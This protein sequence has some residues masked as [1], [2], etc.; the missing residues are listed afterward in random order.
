MLDKMKDRFTERIATCDRV[1]LEQALIRLGMGLVILVYLLYRY[2]TRT[3]LNHNDT[4]SFR[5]LGVFLLLALILIGSILYSRKPSVIRR[6]AGAWVDQG[7]TTLFMALTGEVGVVLVGVYLWVIFGNGFRFGNKYLFHAQLLS[8]AGFIVTTQVSPYWKNHSPIIYGVLVMLFTL[9]IY[10]SALI[11]RMNEARQKAEEA[12]AAKTRFVANMSHEIRTPLNGIIGISTLLKTTPLNNEQQ[13]LLGM[14]DSSSR[15]LLS[16]LNN[17]LD[18]AKIEDGKMT[19]ENTDFSV[20]SILEETANIFSSQAEVKGVRLDTCI[21]AEVGRLH[22]DS[23]RL[24]QVLAN[25]VGNAVKFTERGSVTLSFSVLGEDEHSSNVRFEVAD[26]GVGIPASAQGKIF[27]S[28]TQ[29]DLSTSRRFG[30]SGLGLTLTKHLVEAMGGRLSFESTEGLGSRFWFDLTLERVTQ[31]QP[32]GA[33]VVLLPYTLDASLQDTLH[34][35]VCENDSTNQKIL[36]RL[37]ELAGHHVSMTSNGEELLDQLEQ[38]AFDLVI[39]DLNM[40]GMSGTE[41]L[42]LYRFTRPDD[43]RTRFILF[44][45][46]ATQSARQAAREAGFDAFLGKPVDAPVLFG[47]IANLLGMPPTTAENW[48]NT[49]M[50]GTDSGLSAAATAAETG[51]VLDATTLRE[52]ETLGA[53]DA[54]FVPR[55]LSNYLRD[56]DELLDKIGHAIK[57]KHYGALRDH[58]HALKGNSL[59]IGARGVFVRAETIDRADTGELRFRGA[60]MTELLRMDYAAVRGAIENYLT[61]R[62]ADSR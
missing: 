21:A 27:E 46:D 3:A 6:L 12:S 23:L 4:I 49:A 52:L 8:V 16:L 50:G 41:A 62:Q 2:I 36:L 39:S 34:I 37:L 20:N 7:G 32:A 17:V 53:G 61:R 33:K 9:P 10:V 15:L 1:E 18:F 54:L 56:S 38:G 22:G 58:C 13:D 55:L 44:T 29:A 48:L 11:R 24:Q 60:T 31:V 51:A 47:T 30:G 19:I 28:F 42:K 26:T 59:G 35:L 40:A 57:H 14:L 43:T 25:L 45:A 5:V